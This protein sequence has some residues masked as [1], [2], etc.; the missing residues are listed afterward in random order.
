MLVKS[1]SHFQFRSL[2]HSCSRQKPL[3]CQLPNGVTMGQTITV[4]QLHGRPDEQR[5]SRR[6]PARP[7]PRPET[8]P[9]SRWPPTPRCLSPGW[10]RSYSWRAAAT[11]PGRCTGSPRCRRCP[12]SPGSRS[13]SAASRPPTCWTPRGAPGAS[14]P[15]IVGMPG[16]QDPRCQCQ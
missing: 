6:W 8:S 1:K 12:G 15:E 16:D 10:P 9:S 14:L 3:Q 2:C 11:A 5:A 13:A 7:R 4:K